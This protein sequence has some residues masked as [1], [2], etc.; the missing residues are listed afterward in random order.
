MTRYLLDPDHSTFEYSLRYLVMRA[1]GR[2][3]NFAG[4]IDIDPDDITRSQLTIQVDAASITTDDP[5]RDVTPRSAGFLDL[6]SD[7]LI[8]LTSKRFEQDGHQL[9]VV[10]ALSMNGVTRDVV[11]HLEPLVAVTP[12]YQPDQIAFFASTTIHRKDFALHG[13]PLSGDEVELSLDIRAT[14]ADA[15]ADVNQIGSAPWAPATDAASLR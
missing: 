9:R 10:A 3:T 12:A 5:D 13:N 6:A 2:F 15:G 4:V 7:P 1:R 14:R 11:L 8:E